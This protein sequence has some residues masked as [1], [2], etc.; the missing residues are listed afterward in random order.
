MIKSKYNIG[1]FIKAENIKTKKYSYARIRGY[2]KETD[3]YTI[4][5]IYTT[6]D[7]YL[8]GT[9]DSTLKGNEYHIIKKVDKGKVFAEML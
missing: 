1:D 9:I 8:L 7:R 3:T 4:D 2:D 6:E 5:D